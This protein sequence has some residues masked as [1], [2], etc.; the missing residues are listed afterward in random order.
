VSAERVL[1]DT[2]VFC[3]GRQAADFCDCGGDCTTSSCACCATTGDTVATTLATAKAVVAVTT[4]RATPAAAAADTDANT[5]TA[6]AVA[7]GLAA[8]ETVTSP[9][10]AASWPACTR[11]ELECASQATSQSS[12]PHRHA[13]AAADALANVALASA[14][15]LCPV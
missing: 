6:A 4:S 10:V 2:P 9:A 12:Y 15:A 14:A 7:A 5:A 13:G 8:V 11:E 1:S 3:A